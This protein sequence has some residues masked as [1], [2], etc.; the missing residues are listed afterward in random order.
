[1][2]PLTLAVASLIAWSAAFPVLSAQEQVH[3]PPGYVLVDDMI[4]PE[5]VVLGDA[6]FTATPWPFGVVPYAFNANVTPANQTRVLE[7]MADISAVCGVIFIPHTTTPDWLIFNSAT[8]NSSPVG[9]IGG[10]QT[11]PR[12]T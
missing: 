8:V 10:G 5:E 1:M 12:S 11:G 2:R 4:L 6:T 7:A 9:V 3:V